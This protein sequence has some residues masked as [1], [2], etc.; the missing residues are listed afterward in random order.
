[1]KP[2]QNYGTAVLLTVGA[3]FLIVCGGLNAG[4]VIPVALIIGAVMAALLVK[5]I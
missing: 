4:L 2:E 1:M 5:D 3:A